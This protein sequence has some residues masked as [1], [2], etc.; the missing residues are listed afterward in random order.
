MV[1][2]TGDP[3]FTR[4]LHGK[5]TATLSNLGDGPPKSQPVPCRRWLEL[6]LLTFFLLV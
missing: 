1:K 5:S 2:G 4:S 6:C 3:F